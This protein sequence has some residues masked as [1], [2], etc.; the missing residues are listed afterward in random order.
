VGGSEF[1]D[2]LK[3]FYLGFGAEFHPIEQFALR[4]GYNTIG[5]D[6]KVGTKKDFMAGI[7]LGV[8]FDMTLVRM[9][10]ALASHGELGF[11]QR[12]ALSKTF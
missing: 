8:G 6:Q 3:H 12:I 10:Y 1:I 7:C 9:D 2:F 5:L 4:I 11:V